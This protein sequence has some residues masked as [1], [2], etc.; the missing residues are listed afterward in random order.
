[1]TSGPCNFSIQAESGFEL[2][3]KRTLPNHGGRFF[4][5]RLTYLAVNHRIALVP[6]VCNFAFGI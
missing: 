1:M 5:L 2:R 4:A 3:A 6:W